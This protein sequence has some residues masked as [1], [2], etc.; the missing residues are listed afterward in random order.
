MRIIILLFFVINLFANDINT[1]ELNNTDLNNTTQNEFNDIDTPTDIFT[2]DLSNQNE[3]NITQ[4]IIDDNDYN[5]DIAIILDKNKFFEFIPSLLNSINAYMIKKDINYHIHIFNQ[6]KNLTQE[7][8][9]ITPNYKYIFTYFTNPE[10]IKILN[11]YP[12]NYFFVPTL[13]K[14]QIH[15]QTNNNIFFGGI[16]YKSQIQHL[17]QYISN[18]AMIVYDNSDISRYITT[19]L[20]ETLLEPH[21]IVKYPIRDLN[22]FNQTFVYLNTQIVNTAQILS[23]F[24]YK[25]I[26]TKAVFSTQLNYTPTLFS[27]TNPEDVDNFI[28]ANSILDISP[29]VEDNNL[30]LGS[31]IDFNWLDFTTSAL[32]NIANNIETLDDVSFVNDFGIYMFYNQ[33]FYKT[34]LYKIFQNGFIK[35]EN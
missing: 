15:F 19:L 1:T 21:K 28:I 33:V 9:N 24:T 27:L 16:N 17:N 35:I 2:L 23:N 5:M 7:L 29:I 11:N 22:E 18:Y 26:D 8:N 6:E 12:N 10:N 30:N 25:E 32:L 3:E 34:N 31:D 4:D 20:D 14:Y 13:N